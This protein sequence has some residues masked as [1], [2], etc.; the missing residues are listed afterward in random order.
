MRKR[1]DLQPENE[2]SLIQNE[3]NY[4]IKDM[5]DAPSVWSWKGEGRNIALLFFLYL[6]QGIPLGLI[7][8]IPLMLQNRHVSYKEQAEFSLVF[9]PFSLK[10]LW[11]PIV[12]SLYS[13][14]MGRR[15]TWVLIIGY[16]TLSFLNVSIF[17]HVA[18]SSS[19]SLGNCH[20]IFINKSGPI[21]G[22]WRVAQYKS[23]NYSILYSKFLSCNSRHCS[24]WLGFDYVTQV[25]NILCFLVNNSILY[26][27]C[28][29]C[30]GKMWAMLPLAT[31][32]VKLLVIFWVML[33]LWHLNLQIFA[34]N[35][36]GVNPNQMVS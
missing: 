15:K 33:S 30:A 34:T 5:K 29:C 9:W 6:L 26:F 32:L 1:G 12:D 10:L 2:R 28:S 27:L 21:L 17:L 23:T 3:S 31:V 25:N 7:A 11:A 22:C 24:W 20:V 13:S 8:S 35:I 18:C 36:W 14:R 16:F 19:I 4:Q